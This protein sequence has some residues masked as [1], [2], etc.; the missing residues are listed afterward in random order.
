MGIK[1]IKITNFKC[2]KERFEVSFQSGLNI[3]VGRNEIGKSTILEAIHLAFTGY[4]QG[5]TIR[6]DLTQHLFNKVAVDDYLEAIK[7]SDKI[8][9]PPKIEIEVYF[10]SVGE[11]PELMG[12]GNSDKDD[13]AVG[14]VFSISY[15]EYYSKTYESLWNN[16]Q[17]ELNSLPLEYYH[18]KWESFG[19]MGISPRDIKQNCSLIDSSRPSYRSISDIYVSRI[20]TNTLSEDDRITLA[21]ER[22]K[23]SAV[24]SKS[25]NVSEINARL[26]EDQLMR[27][28][29]I[30]LGVDVGSSNEWENTLVALS[31]GI[32]FPFVGKGM[33]CVLKTKMSIQT[34]TNKNTPYPSI[35]LIEEPES[36]LSHSNLHRILSDIKDN[37]GNNQ[38]IIST[39]SSYVAN[40]IGLE[41]VIVLG[42]E[43]PMSFSNLEKRTYEY[44]KKLSGYDTLRYVL[45]N[46]AILVE[47]P[48]DDLIVQRAYHD[49]YG[50]FPEDDGI[51]VIA[52]GRSF[53]RFLEIAERLNKKTI[54]VTDN[55]GNPESLNCKYNKYNSSRETPIRIYYDRE[56][57]EATSD[58]KKDLGDNFNYNTLEP[59]LLRANSTDKLIRVLKPILPDGIGS[60]ATLLKFMKG[61]KTD[62]AL[63]IYESD[64]KISYPEYIESAIDYASKRDNK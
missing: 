63:T 64:E 45:S 10:D 8:I 48:S 62:C 6:R 4:Y 11:S 54:I 56:T 37:L 28:H 9:M 58:L 30:S 51:D 59:C 1:K 60:E 26:K 5:H 7:T 43:N 17:T 42:G 18:I 23:L 50:K 33:Q 29:K 34:N 20:V 61:H 47:G 12:N 16:R 3:L 49:K 35:I 41:R 19:R 14:F 55:D 57:S 36:H 39:H 40:K 24:F 32:P 38:I 46:V 2:Y 44:F 53:S 25:S 52:V 27:D 22:R 13:N 21:R 15:D 31:D